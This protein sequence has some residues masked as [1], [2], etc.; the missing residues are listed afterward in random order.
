MAKAILLVRV[1]T[2]KQSFDEQEKQVYNMAIADGYTD[3]DIIIIAEKE[4][5]IKLT[6]EQRKGLNRMKEVIATEN[7]AVVYAWEISRIARKKKVLFSILEYLTECKIQLAIYEPNIRLL[8]DDK[9]INDASETIF[10]LFAQMAESEMRTKV[11]RWTRTKKAMAEQGKWTGGNKPHFGYSVDKETKKY[12]INED[13]AKVIRMIFDLYVNSN[14]GYNRIAREL[15]QRGYKMSRNVI[16]KIV[17]DPTFT[18]KHQ[19]VRT[20][21][22]KK[23]YGNQ[24]AWPVIIDLDT[25]EKAVDKRKNTD[26]AH[27]KSSKYYFGALL[28]ECPNCG[29]H[30]TVTANKDYR[31]MGCGG[32]GTIAL[33]LIDSLLWYD[34]V[35][36][37]QM[38]LALYRNNNMVDLDAQLQVLREKVAH[39][40]KVIGSVDDVLERIAVS[41]QDGMITREKMLSQRDGVLAKIKD[42]EQDRQQYLSN[43]EK[44]ETMKQTLDNDNNLVSRLNRIDEEIKGIEDF[45]Q[46]YEIIHQ[47]I[48][49]VTVKN[50]EFNGNKYVKE[51]AIYH[52]TTGEVHRFHYYHKKQKGCKLYHYTFN[53]NSPIH[54]ELSKRGHSFESEVEGIKWIKRAKK[55]T[56]KSSK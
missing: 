46:M 38:Q 51:I 28:I 12:I 14:M 31:C 39:C 48:D 44:I 45:R 11:A 34:T 10:T 37:Y 4:S 8:N 1:S 43:I 24:R 22:G 20:I 54:I 33:D 30:F 47:Y 40:E 23:Y 19:D 55:R 3:D 52:I 50:I 9:T 18:G 6:E 56:K 53:E 13:E 35:D 36:D 49:H 26:K 25:W 29:R 16:G 42:A 15:A 5:G 2:T 7:V 21:K 41:F 17:S 32:N 27:D